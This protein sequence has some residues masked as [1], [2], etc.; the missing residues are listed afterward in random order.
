MGLVLAIDLSV[1]MVKSLVFGAQVS[2]QEASGSFVPALAGN[3]LLNFWPNIINALLVA[4]RVKQL[5]PS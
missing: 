3:Q 4:P 1:D 2:A 5:R